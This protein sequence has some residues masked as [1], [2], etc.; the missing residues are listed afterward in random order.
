M[1]WGGSYRQFALISSQNNI[2]ATATIS[3]FIVKKD[4]TSYYWC[5]TIIR[6]GTKPKK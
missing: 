1:W 2:L 5:D 6:F 3:E 4:D